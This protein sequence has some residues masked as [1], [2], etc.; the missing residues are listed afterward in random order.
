VLVKFGVGSQ[1][2][3]ILIRLVLFWAH[4]WVNDILYAVKSLWGLVIHLSINKSFH[5]KFSVSLVLIT[6]LF[7][8]R[9]DE[10]SS[11]DCYL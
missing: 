4:I 6:Y 11:H 8:V 3:S 2:N 9:F 5:D 1:N 10:L 7:Y